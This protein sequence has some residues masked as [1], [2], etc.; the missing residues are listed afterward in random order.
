MTIPNIGVNNNQR[1]GDNVFVESLDLNFSLQLNSISSSLPIQ[2]RIVIG[3]YKKEYSTNFV[4]TSVSSSLLTTLFSNL[5]IGNYS[6]IY[7][8]IPFNTNL[9]IL[10]DICSS[11]NNHSP[12]VFINRS[13]LINNYLLFNSSI[14]SDNSPV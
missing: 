5:F 14:N 1:V 13:Y 4:W 9:I 12:L 2:Y 8:S 7:Q 6:N 3:L 10:D 11:L